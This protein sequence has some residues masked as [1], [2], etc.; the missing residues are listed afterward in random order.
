MLADEQLDAV[1]IATPA[2]T[3][4]TLAKQA[5]EAGKH[6]F[7]E[8]PPAVTTEQM[9]DLIR[10]ATRQGL[11]LMPGHLMLYHPGFVSLKNA[12]DEGEIG[13]IQSVHFDR[14]SPGPTGGDIGVLWDLGPHDVSMAIALFGAPDKTSAWMTED[15]VYGHLGFPSGVTAH[16]YMSRLSSVKTRRITIVGEDGVLSFDDSVSDV[17]AISSRGVSATSWSPIPVSGGEPLRAECSHF[18]H[19]IHGGWSG[20]EM[21]AGL[22]VVRVLEEMDC[23]ELTDVVKNSSRDERMFATI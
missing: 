8:K 7:V 6:V 18:L 10:T 22:A 23:G 11:V 19:S 2:T 12:L 20:E 1:V 9:K 16:L 3:H 5:L 4:H 13:K 15:V 21:R 14:L 17:L